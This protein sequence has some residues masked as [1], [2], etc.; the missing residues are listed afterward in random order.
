MNYSIYHVEQYG[1]GKREAN[2]LPES[3]KVTIAD[4]DGHYDV[5]EC[6]SDKE[7]ES[8]ANW[9]VSAVYETYPEEVSLNKLNS[10]FFSVEIAE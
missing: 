6:D 3:Q 7:A 10:R 8:I 1:H 5:Y 2:N 9:Y 4:H